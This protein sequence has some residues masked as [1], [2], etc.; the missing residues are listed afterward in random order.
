MIE[1]DKVQLYEVYKDK[2]KAYISGKVNHIQDAEDLISTV[3]LKIYQNT[4]K[5]DQSRASLS[6]W[7]YTITK[8][9]VIDYYRTRKVYCELEE[10]SDCENGIS[11]TFEIE[12]ML[13]MLCEALEKL[14]KKHRDLIILHYYEEK[15]LKEIAGILN[16]SYVYAKIIHRKALQNLEELLKQ[17]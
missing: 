2:V 5:F 7:I 6:T 16:I 3:F 10:I 9:T 14:P 11:G 13:E 4:D 1:T 15:P 17:R 8:N 12:Y